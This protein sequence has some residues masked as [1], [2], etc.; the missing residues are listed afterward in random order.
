[1]T[2]KG[3]T[4]LKKVLSIAALLLSLA[5]LQSPLWRPEAA[6]R[7]VTAKAGGTVTVP[8]DGQ[9]DKAVIFRR[10]MAT[11]SAGSPGQLVIHAHAPGKTS[12]LIRYKDGD[13]VLYEVIVLPG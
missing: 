10:R 5:A 7:S 9:L 11:L 8:Y 13:S 1:M 6:T 2:E 12:M 4:Y 3:S